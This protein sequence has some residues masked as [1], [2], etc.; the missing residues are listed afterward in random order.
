MKT[1]NLALITAGL[2]LICSTAMA[3]GTSAK[4]YTVIFESAGQTFTVE[5]MEIMNTAGKVS[6]N[7]SGKLPSGAWQCL[8][9]AS[10]FNGNIKGSY[11]ARFTSYDSKSNV[12]LTDFIQNGIRNLGFP[13]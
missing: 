3:I 9:T 10:P 11:T 1:I 8:V 7:C 12:C 5:S 13:L 2:T 6:K 4:A